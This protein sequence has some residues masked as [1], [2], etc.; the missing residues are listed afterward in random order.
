MDNIHL[1]EQERKL[2]LLLIRFMQKN[3]EAK[4]TAEGIARWWIM[5]QKFE[6]EIE[7]IK[8]VL[9]YLTKVGVLQEIAPTQNQRYYKINNQSVIHFIKEI[10][11]EHI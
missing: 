7:K 6:E 4:H 11:P 10:E 1:T 2:A 5:Q 3:S 9:E 8:K